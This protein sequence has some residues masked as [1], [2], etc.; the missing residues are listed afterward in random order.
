METENNKVNYLEVLKL[1]IPGLDREQP[2][3]L[4][5]DA[6]HRNSGEITLANLFDL[7]KLKFG[8]NPY[9][10]IEEREAMRKNGRVTSGVKPNCEMF[11]I[12]KGTVRLLEKLEGIYSP[13]YASHAEHSFAQGLTEAKP[14]EVLEV[15]YVSNTSTLGSPAVVLSNFVLAE[16]Q[17]RENPIRVSP[18]MTTRQILDLLETT[19]GAVK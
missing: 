2:Y 4:F 5:V 14:D 16:H 19:E 13:N 9:H 8:R 15:S 17:S 1:S 12:R 11:P 7:A 6:M 18:G 10:V 3:K